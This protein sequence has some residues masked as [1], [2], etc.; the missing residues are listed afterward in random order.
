MNVI[1]TAVVIEAMRKKH[2]T[3]TETCANCGVTSKTLRSVLMGKVPQ[4]IDALF[5]ILDGLELTAE[6][7]LTNAST[8]KKAG[9]YLVAR[10]RGGPQ[11]A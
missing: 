11:I 9:L 8:S 3:V 2:W 5:R 4:R 1:K 6:E 10:G 7:A